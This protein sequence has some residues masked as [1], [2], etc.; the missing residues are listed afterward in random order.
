MERTRKRVCFVTVICLAMTAPY[1]LSAEPLSKTK[2]RP[3]LG[4][5]PMKKLSVTMD[6]DKRDR[7]FKANERIKMKFV[8]KNESNTPIRV[9]IWGTPLE[10]LNSN[11]FDITGPDGEK[12]PYLGKIVSRPAPDPAKDYITIQPGKSIEKE[13]DINDAYHIEKDGTYSLSHNFKM[14]DLKLIK[15]L[16]ATPEMSTRAPIEL[17]PILFQQEGIRQKTPRK[18]LQEAPPV[19]P[20]ARMHAQGPG[21][22]TADLPP[23]T[24]NRK[25]KLSHVLLPEYATTDNNRKA[26]LNEAFCEALKLAAEAKVTLSGTPGQE[27]ESGADRYRAY[28]GDADKKD[29]LSVFGTIHTFGFPTQGSPVQFYDVTFEVCHAVVGEA[30]SQYIAFVMGDDVLTHLKKIYLCPLFWTLSDSRFTKSRIVLHEMA[31]LTRSAEYETIPKP[32]Y[33]ARVWDY[34]YFESGCMYLAQNDPEHAAFNADSF[35]LFAAN[36]N[37][38]NMGL[39]RPYVKFSKAAGESLVVENKVLRVRSNADPSKIQFAV[40][41][42]KE[43][44]LIYPSAVNNACKYMSEF[45]NKCGNCDDPDAA[46]ASCD[47]EACSCVVQID[48]NWKPFTP[49]FGDVVTLITGNRASVLDAPGT[50][51]KA[52]G[53]T[54]LSE[55]SKGLRLVNA[56]SASSRLVDGA[57]IYLQTINGLYLSEADDGKVITKN[58]TNPSSTERFNISFSRQGKYYL[59]MRT[60]SKGWYVRAR[61]DLLGRSI[62]ADVE[63]QDSAGCADCTFILIKQ[64]QEPLT[65]GDVINL[66]TYDGSFVYA[67]NETL[68]GFVRADGSGNSI[69]QSFIVQKVNPGDE[70]TI[71]TGDVIYL[72][73][74]TEDGKFPVWTSPQGKGQLYAS[75]NPGVEEQARKFIIE[76]GR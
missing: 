38:L 37:D 32:G 61:E 20:P 65:S 49:A 16:G 55:S 31:H 45:L 64:N 30:E 57:E 67:L 5:G 53:E 35:A 39:D 66:M 28:F 70:N 19:R 33:R 58:V 75:N 41:S 22:T 76:L 54:E 11:L 10:G 72:F 63:V 48:R 7:V 52:V 23:Y 42:P 40:S 43:S 18:S 9:L 69:P 44:K 25:C 56:G 24:G 62:A 73:S 36:R 47:K 13:I 68:W 29:V 21:Q 2:S 71:G 15:G 60:E 3:A 51:E 4:I 46:P 14:L 59:Q 34:N 74:K 26:E 8:M 27:I 1:L 17:Q 6:I 12:V 50:T